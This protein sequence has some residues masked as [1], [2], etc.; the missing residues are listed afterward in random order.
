LKLE[1]ERITVVERGRDP[2]RFEPVGLTREEAR[3]R[4]GVD[5]D[6]EVVLAVGRQEFQKGLV[7]LLD[8]VAT[9][10]LG[11]PKLVVLIAGRAG[12]ATAAIDARLAARGDL[13]DRVRM[14]GHRDDVPSLLAAADVFALPSLYEGTAGAAIEAMAAS[15]PVVASRVSGMDGVLEDDRNALLVPPGDVGALGVAIARA[16][17]DEALRARLGA[18]GRATFAERFTL[19]RSADEMVALYEDV[20]ARGRRP[21]FTNSRSFV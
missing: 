16:L 18:A 8:A 17:D 15:V 14:L 1:P 9:T 3:A 4:I 21:G 7:H 6:A 10:L 2:A 13:V 12:N 11:R 5:V 19:A 20:A